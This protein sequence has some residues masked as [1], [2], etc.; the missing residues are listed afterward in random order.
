MLNFPPSRIMGR[1][2]LFAA[3]AALGAVALL[4]VSERAQP[5]NP[6][7]NTAVS[8]AWRSDG[9]TLPVGIDDCWELEDVPRERRL[10]CWLDP[11]R[12]HE[13]QRI[14]IIVH[15][16]TDAALSVTCRGCSVD[17]CSE[18]AVTPPVRSTAARCHDI[19]PGLSTG[20][21]EAIL[22]LSDRTQVFG[23]RVIQFSIPPR[24]IVEDLQERWRHAGKLGEQAV[25]ALIP[26]A[27][28]LV[29]AQP[30]GPIRERAQI[31]LALI[32]N[33]RHRLLEKAQGFLEEKDF[34]A[35]I[36]P[37]EQALQ[38]AHARRWLRSEAELSQALA[39]LYLRSG[40]SQNTVESIEK[41]LIGKEWS[42]FLPIQ[43]FHC[44][45]LLID[46]AIER[47]DLR[48]VAHQLAQVRGDAELIN[49][50]KLSSALA[51]VRVAEL[52][53]LVIGGSPEEI[54]RGLH[55][56]ES[57]A[58]RATKDPCEQ[59][60]L[61]GSLGWLK[62]LLVEFGWPIADDPVAVLEQ[63][64]LLRENQCPKADTS[65]A[66]VWANLARARSAAW[67]RSAELNPRQRREAIETT[68][69]ALTGLRRALGSQ[70]EPDSIRQ[71]RLYGEVRLFLLEGKP[72]KALPLFEELSQLAARRK[73]LV[74]SWL[75]AIHR[76][77]ALNAGGQPDDAISAFRKADEQLAPLL[78]QV[79]V[80]QAHRLVLSR[81][82]YSSQRA[83]ELALRAG[84]PDEAMEI[85]RQL[86]QQALGL[87]S[88]PWW[89][90]QTNSSKLEWL[91]RRQEQARYLVQRMDYEK[92]ICLIPGFTLAQ[93]EDLELTKSHW[94][95]SLDSMLA[96]PRPA[97]YL[98]PPTPKDE[99][100]L[101]CMRQQRGWTCI[102]AFDGL[103]KAVP[104]TSVELD[105]RAI[106]QTLLPAL[107]N[108]VRSATKIRVLAHGELAQLD[109]G[110]IAFDGQPLGIQK[111]ILHTLDRPVPPPHP[112]PIQAL[113]LK[114]DDDI[115]ELSLAMTQ[116]WLAPALGKMRI[117]I[118]NAD[119]SL[120][121]PGS[122][123][124]V[125]ALSSNVLPQLQS[126]DV[127]IYFG[128]IGPP[129]CPKSILCCSE[130]RRSS[131]RPDDRLTALHLS[132]Y[133]SLTNADILAAERV[134]QRAFLLGCAAT[135]RS[136]STPAEIL[137]LAQAFALRG[138][139]VLAFGRRIKA[140]D[141]AEVL[142]ALSQQRLDNP[143][144]DLGRFVM[145]TQRR[146]FK[147][148]RCKA[149]GKWYL[150]SCSQAAG[151]CS[152]PVDWQA[153]RW[154]GP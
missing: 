150:P 56:L 17:A 75:I 102:S 139:Q 68:R 58:K 122:W 64:R 40:S 105:A 87:T 38:L 49:D 9:P 53:T 43:K 80:Y 5:E 125:E 145:D 59:S 25:Q 14:R 33:D 104:I 100:L 148:E 21:S 50:A 98:S 24:T 137:G 41:L 19:R 123:M 72:Q 18:N 120:P 30:S 35:T 82:Q 74:D 143:D 91:K 32:I 132:Q 63:A 11:L 57:A 3:V 89:P 77:E 96:E 153:L 130:G 6:S 140:Q 126:S 66:N 4:L 34:V 103:Y 7:K 83:V 99:L 20:H 93:C 2:L 44:Y 81:F 124:H 116:R 37:L 154:Y 114:P 48:R 144:F 90:E 127:F 112:Y 26:E 94:L 52:E 62:L 12:A 109:L 8:V 69:S 73:W 117:V 84:R 55:E 133:N 110:A 147:G 88:V 86:D 76:A 128:H 45:R 70:V 101:G 134:P 141:A 54:Q 60:S 107:A 65:L 22:Q 146:F 152:A 149:Q 95:N 135:D 36:F 42:Q 51:E 46:A 1:Y 121:T 106:S 142:C 118:S 92:Q 67:W 78:Q 113:V 28:A 108:R 31:L 13:Q 85:L 115:H 29:A 47:Q 16:T 27:Q 15:D 39:W 151:D 23:E 61:L 129:P 131:L 136:A 71:D 79:P 97:A 111:P 119:M 10:I 138:A